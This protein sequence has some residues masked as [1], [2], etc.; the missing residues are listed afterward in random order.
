MSSPIGLAVTPF[1]S[2]SLANSTPESKR[3]I[4]PAAETSSSKRVLVLTTPSTQP[5][6]VSPGATFS[7][8]PLFAPKQLFPGGEAKIAQ[9]YTHSH[10]PPVPWRQDKD[11][12]AIWHNKHVLLPYNLRDP[13]V[14]IHSK[15]MQT[16]LCGIF[17]G[18]FNVAQGRFHLI[19]QVNTLPSPP[20]PLTVGG[21]PFTLVAENGPS[22]RALIFPRLMYGNRAISICSEDHYT[23]AVVFSDA[24][25]RRLAADVNAY[26]LK[27]APPG[28]RLLELMYTC[29]C[30]FYIVLD[31]HVDIP[32][33]RVKLPGRIANWVVGYIHNHDL[34]RPS[35]ADIPAKREVQP[36]PLAGVIDNTAYDILRPGV[37]IRS[38]M[39]RDHAHPG[40]FSTT[41]GVLVQNAKG[42]RFMTAA[43][44]GIGEGETVW[45]A[46]RP[47]RAIGEAVVEISFTDVSLLK[48]KD[49]VEFVNETFETDAGV[50]P[51][52]V[53]LKTSTEQLPLISD[54]YLNSPY[55]GN[56]Y[57]T[58]VARSA[59]LFE[60]SPYLTERQ[61][62][63]IVYDWCYSGQ[64]EGNEGKFQP[65]DG[66]CGSV[67][68][69]DE[70]VI[71]G[72]Y[73]YCI[74]DG[75]WAGFSASVSASAVVDAGY[76]LAK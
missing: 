49:D 39:L 40:V 15:E 19:F 32:A 28:V 20:W 54:Y 45:Q 36:L 7:T 13:K 59:R 55:T 68:W 70:G 30:T 12:D 75:A 1:R 33:T 29:E 42:D 34:G 48:L 21:M 43:S 35:W 60:T 76:S 71:T 25:L 74:Q 50:V 6:N 16:L 66:T 41:S 18:T 14:N 2:G 56:L 8:K 63:Y 52:F 11:K 9:Q 72:F 57:A 27:D 67:I 47:D 22:G 65:P 61:L 62:E 26:F 69:N 23:N 53:R 31:D 44:H 17:P 64:E 58:L 46:D 3:K 73:H 38:K 4:S 37:L 24:L 10:P 5:S 51:E